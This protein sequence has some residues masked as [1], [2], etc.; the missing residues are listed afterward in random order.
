MMAATF[1]P[2]DEDDLSML[3]ERK[4]DCTEFEAK[5][6]TTE[7]LSAHGLE[8]GSEKELAVA[9]CA[10]DGRLDHVGAKASQVQQGSPHLLDRR[11]LSSFIAHNAPLTHELPSRLELRLH[12][13]DYLPAT[14][15]VCG[16][17]GAQAHGGPG[18]S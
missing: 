12:Q 4:K 7:P 14:A 13:H 1:S 10:E 2:E 9:L 16:P 6:L 5:T 18:K 8:N 3:D 11:Q 17:R 15:L